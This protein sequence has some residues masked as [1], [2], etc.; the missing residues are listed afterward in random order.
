MSAEGERFDP[1]THQALGEVDTA[2]PDLVGTVAATQRS[3]Y[4]D[5]GRLTRE[6]AVL[7]YR[8]TD[9]GHER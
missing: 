3:G 9:D 7:V 5:H 6:P 8:L 1:A 2:E 4:I